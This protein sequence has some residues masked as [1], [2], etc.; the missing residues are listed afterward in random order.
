MVLGPIQGIL[1]PNFRATLGFWK[2]LAYLIGA[3]NVIYALFFC[4]VMGLFFLIHC[5]KQNVRLQ[6]PVFNEGSLIR[7]NPNGIMTIS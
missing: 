5:E 3:G 4:L 2:M 1:T 6:V 7:L